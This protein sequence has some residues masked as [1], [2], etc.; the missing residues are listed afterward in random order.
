MRGVDYETFWERTPHGVPGATSEEFPALTGP[1]YFNEFVIPDRTKT[2]TSEDG[3]IVWTEVPAG[4]Y[5][6]V[7]S[8]PTTGFASFLATCADG[9]IINANLPWGAYELSDGEQPLAAG[10]VASAATGVDAKDGRQRRVI[11]TLEG[12]E[13][14]H[15]NAVLRKGGKRIGHTRIDSLPAGTRK[16]KVPVRARAG[17]GGARLTIKLRDAARDVVTTKHRVRLPAA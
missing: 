12:G 14:V 3:G 2:E 17:R 10:V 7:T 11:A 15:V 8:S 6:I 4:T 1:I 9:R 16:V 5:R 13:A